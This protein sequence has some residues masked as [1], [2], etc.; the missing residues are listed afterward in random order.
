MPPR[1]ATN[2]FNLFFDKR[3]VSNYYT[4]MEGVSFLLLCS[5][6]GAGAL[7]ALAISLGWEKRTY[8]LR[9]RLDAA[10]ADLALLNGRVLAEIKRRSGKEGLD[11]RSRNR[12]IEALARDLPTEKNEQIVQRPWWE[13][14]K[15]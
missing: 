9:T 13:V 15:S 8:A 1:P 14:V 2:I 12:E 3:K 5:G 7:A 10:E 11:Q 4:C 6:I